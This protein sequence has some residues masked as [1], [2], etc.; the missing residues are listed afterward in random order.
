MKKILVSTIAVSALLFTV[1][2]KTDFDTDVKSITVTNGDADF[3][4]YVALGNS[5]TA[6]YRDNALYI[7]GQNESYPSM[8]AAQMQLAGGGAF[9]Q[10]LMPNNTGGFT[11]LPGFPGKLT[12]QVVNGALAPVPSAAAAVLDNITSTGPYQN[13]GVP[14]AKSFHLGAAGY[15]NAAGL[16]AGLANPYYVRFATGAT[17]SVLNDALSQNPTFFSLWIGNNDVLSYAT[18]GGIGV[19]RTGN[20]DPTTYGSNDITD[21]TVYASVIN[22]Y[23]TALT[24]NGAKG[25]IANIPN[26]TSIP[27]FTRVPYNAIPLTAAKAQAL[28]TGLYQPLK[29]ALT[30]LG[31]GSRINLVN[32]GNNPV[33]IVDRKLTNLSAQ[34]TAVLTASGVPATQAAYIGNA[35]GQARQATSEELILLTASSV[36]GIDAQTGL[37]ATDTSTFVYGASYPIGDHLSLTKDELTSIRTAVAA[38]NTALKNIATA[39]GLA[40]VDANAKMIE[41][42]SASGIQFDGV[43]YT[44]TFVTGGTFSLDGV[45]LTGRGYALIANEFI[46]AIN[47]KYRS[48]LPQINVNNYSG[49]TFP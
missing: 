39:K 40:F 4:K 16:P 30:Y 35:F 24:T 36:L 28:N 47:Q 34:L 14:G 12:L 19:D 31:A 38:Y 22:G 1:S 27:F 49:V 23:V 21:P 41:L 48:T 13:L 46:K 3:S 9:K 17:A 11:N 7:D 42:S 43:K 26:V 33:L 45:H 37:P 6:G 5:L 25:V 15:G 8:I 44:A 29:A 18:S 20:M 2:C 10:P 32:E